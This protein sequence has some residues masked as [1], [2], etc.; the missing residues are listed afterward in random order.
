MARRKKC[1][2]SDFQ[3]SMTEILAG[4]SDDVI[5]GIHEAIAKTGNETKS[6]V[7][8]NIATSVPPING[9]KYKNSIVAEGSYNR[10]QNTVRVWSPKHYRLTHLLEHGHILIAHGKPYGRTQPREHWAPAEKEA[11]ER[12]NQRIEEAIKQ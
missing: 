5:E 3:R 9:T 1:K 6:L 2:V 7:E 10:Y 11:L 12:L 4:Y 8:T